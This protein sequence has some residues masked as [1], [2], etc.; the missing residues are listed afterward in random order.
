MKHESYGVEEGTLSMVRDT[1]KLYLKVQG[2]WREIQVIYCFLIELNP[3]SL[4]VTMYC[5]SLWYSISWYP[6][7][8]YKMSYCETA[9][10]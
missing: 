2:G 4:P 10:K 6:V 8:V 9:L 1:S 5:E 7:N 3:Y